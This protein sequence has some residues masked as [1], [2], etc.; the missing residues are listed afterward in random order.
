[1]WLVYSMSKEDIWVS[2]V[3][4]PIPTDA[5]TGYTDDQF[6]EFAAG[7]VVPLWHTHAPKWGHLTVADGSLTLRSD[8]PYDYASATR[9]FGESTSK[10]VSVELIIVG[11]PKATIEIDLRP[12]FG[13]ARPITIQFATTGEVLAL[14]A[15]GPV[16]FGCWVEGRLLTLTLIGI[17]C[18]Q[19]RY[20]AS[21]DSG[22][23]T[24]IRFAESAPSVQRIVLRTGPFRGNGG[25]SPVPP[26]TDR[27]T[28]G[29]TLK[30]LRVWVTPEDGYKPDDRR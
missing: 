7:P 18:D 15:A 16:A 11:Q 9:P 17:S 4:L 14:G 8:D 30:V 28:P 26:G 27:P 25:A 19:G 3:P 5:P 10:D 22:K 29:A 1:M 6:A 20:Y 24:Q 12:K 2:R 13:A 21:I 23:V